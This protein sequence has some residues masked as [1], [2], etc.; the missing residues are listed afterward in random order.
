MTS[1]KLFA[2][3][4]K[5]LVL[6][7]LLCLALYSL[8]YGKRPRI[9]HD[10]GAVEL[11]YWEKWGGVEAA[12]MKEIVTDFNNTVGR[13]KHIYINYQ[14]IALVD[15]KVL[16]A[17]AAGT[18][19]DIAG[20]WDGQLPAWAAID[21]IEPLDDLAKSHG[22][23]PDIYKPIMWSSCTFEGHLYAVVS[24]PGNTALIYNKKMFHDNAAE[25]RA[26]GCDPDRAPETID[27]LNKYAAAL[28]KWETVG[29]RKRLVRTGYHPL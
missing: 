6:A 15:R 17:T 21:A 25:L 14:S 28:D 13:D 19:P 8:L 22:I 20:V 24:T 4:L 27:E 5:R 18:P 26:A 1:L 9:E 12:Q 7:I 10:P 23:T 29:N 3:L 2:R 11:Q 16:L